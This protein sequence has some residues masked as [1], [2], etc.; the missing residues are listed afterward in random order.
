VIPVQKSLHGPAG[1]HIAL[2]IAPN[3]GIITGGSND[4]AISEEKESKVVAA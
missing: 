1:R 2:D 3:F 4:V